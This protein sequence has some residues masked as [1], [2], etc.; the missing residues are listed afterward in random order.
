MSE[1]VSTEDPKTSVVVSRVIAQPIAKVWAV[2]MTKDGSEAL[3]G[4][5]A[6]P[7]EKGQTWTAADGRTGVV[8][9]VHRGEQ[10]RFWWRKSEELPPSLVDLTLAP[11]DD[12]HTLV[13]VEHSHLRPDLD[14]AYLQGWWEASVERIES[15]AF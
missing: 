2:L 3:L 9:S 15:D 4:R 13:K 12:D 5:G 8:R 11:T 1:Q 14:P 6:V 7:G 10:I